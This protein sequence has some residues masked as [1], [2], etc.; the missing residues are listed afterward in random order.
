[1]CPLTT[2]A[3]LFNILS[4]NIRTDGRTDIVI[5]IKLYCKLVHV[6][7]VMEHCP[8]GRTQPLELTSSIVQTIYA[9]HFYGVSLGKK[10]GA[11]PR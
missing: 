2:H 3:P 1:M 6:T 10:L 5:K 9:G 8:N 7:F 11:L 4:Q